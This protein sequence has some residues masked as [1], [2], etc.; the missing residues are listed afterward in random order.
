[1]VL[2][3]FLVGVPLGAL[4]GGVLTRRLGYR[5]PAAAG[6]ALAAAMLAVMSTWGPGA[7]ASQLFGLSFAHASDPVLVL[8]GV[9]M[10]ATIAPLTTSLLNCTPDDLHG[11]AAS[12]VVV[13]RMV[14]MVVGVSLLT[15]VGLHTL[16]TRAAALPSPAE[17]CP[18]TPL[19]CPRYD[20]LFTDALT[21]ELTVIFFSAALACGFSLLVVLAT[22]KSAKPAAQLEVTATGP[23]PEGRAGR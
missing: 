3:R 20:R 7:L 17:L 22:Q 5:W 18:G 19:S 2:V 12:L 11:L 15:T 1:L 23:R 16:S 4:V 6:A 13:A 8:C 10:G 14:G 21:S 9:G